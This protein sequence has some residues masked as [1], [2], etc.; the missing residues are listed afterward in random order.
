MNKT[1]LLVIAILAIAAS[2]AMKVM[3][4]SSHLTELD[5]YWWIPLP[6]ALICL[7]IAAS[8]KNN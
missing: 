4:K 7:V 2:I 6:L 8:K 3:A 5:S 1:V